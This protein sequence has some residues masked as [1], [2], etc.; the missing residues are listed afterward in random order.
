MLRRH[1]ATRVGAFR[2]TRRSR[3][4]IRV[5]AR[6]VATVL[7]LRVAALSVVSPRAFAQ[8]PAGVAGRWCTSFQIDFEVADQC[9]RGG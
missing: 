3:R 2:W 9:R 4:W 1:S 5:S 8:V 7:G 6:R